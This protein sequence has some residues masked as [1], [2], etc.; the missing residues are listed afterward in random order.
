LQLLS[1]LF[2]EIGTAIG[3]DVNQQSVLAHTITEIVALTET[4]SKENISQQIYSQLGNKTVSE[5]VVIE[6]WSRLKDKKEA[7][8][9]DEKDTNRLVVVSTRIPNSNQH[10][11]NPFSHDPAGK[12]R[13]LIKTETV[14][15]A[16]EKYI[17]WV[18]NSTDS[19]AEWIRKQL[20]SG[21]L[22]DSPILY[23]KELREPSHATA[24]D[25]LVNKYDWNISTVSEQVKSF[26]DQINDFVVEDLAVSVKSTNLQSSVSEFMQS[27]NKIER[28]ALRSLM[29]TKDIIFKCK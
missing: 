21:N 23:Y 6:S 10:F 8:I 14:Q 2:K 28:E 19:R 25:Y 1:D 27:L 7:L 4:I 15:E 3:M 12:T 29:S 24:L 11:G 13:G 17:D 26:K 20:K 9:V 18:I 16:V 22:K 5:N